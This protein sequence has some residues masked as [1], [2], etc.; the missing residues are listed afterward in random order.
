[1]RTVIQRVRSAS[2]LVCDAPEHPGREVATI[3]RGVLALVGFSATERPQALE[4]M[5]N[6]ILA[7]RL[8]NDAEGRLNRSLQDVAA[9]L[10]V[11]PQV[12]LTTSLAKG[13]RPSFHTAAP[14]AAAQHL[15]ESFVRLLKARHPTVQTGVFQAH[16]LVR[17]ENDG[18]VTFVLDES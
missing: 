5:A 3:T 2:V 9:D 14:P 16:M 12:T 11:V 1:M 17:L 8:F 10:L 13:A 15:F 4:R 6:R 18:P 7:L